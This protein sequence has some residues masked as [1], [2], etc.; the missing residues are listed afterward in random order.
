MSE[1]IKA[2]WAEWKPNSVCC[3]H[4]GSWISQGGRG[5]FSIDA[6]AHDDLRS[7]LS[8]VQGPAGVFEGH[9]A[10][11]GMSLVVEEP[12]TAPKQKPVAKKTK[13]AKSSK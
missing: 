13:R 12:A 2:A 5:V 10:Y 7:K 8:R 11:E 9:G 3:D 1:K 4:L 6:M